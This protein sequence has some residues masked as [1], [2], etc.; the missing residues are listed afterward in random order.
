MVYINNFNFLGF[1]SFYFTGFCS[2]EV[3]R[4]QPELALL[5][6]HCHISSFPVVFRKEVA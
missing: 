3:H 2:K 4:C 5:C 6:A 1:E